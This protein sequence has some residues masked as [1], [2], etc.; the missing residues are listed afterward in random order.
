MADFDLTKAIEAALAATYDRLPEDWATAR[1][2]VTDTDVIETA[3]HAAAPIIERAVREQVAAELRA[4]AER[5]D[6]Q[7]EAKFAPTAL[8]FAAD[9][10]EATPDA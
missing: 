9:F 1:D 3:V 5:V 6:A 4:E 2:L 8:C 10:I 7:S